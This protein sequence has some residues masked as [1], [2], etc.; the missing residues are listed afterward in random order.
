MFLAVLAI[1]SPASA[2]P[3]E[4][5]G[6]TPH[7]CTAGQT[8]N[9]TFLSRCA[10]V[11]FAPHIV[12]VGELIDGSAGPATDQCGPG[13]AAAVSWSW[14][15]YPGATNAKG[16]QPKAASCQL[17]T[18]GPTG[19]SG[20]RFVIACI[21]GSSG[22]GGWTSC[23]Y[24]AVTGAGQRAIEGRVLTKSGKPVNGATV[25]VDGPTGGTVQTDPSGSYYAVVDPGQYRVSVRSANAHDAVAFCSGHEAGSIC[26]L[27][28]RHTDGQ[29]D[30][31]APPD[32][33]ALHFS[34]SHVAADGLGHFDGSIDVTDS[35]GQPAAGTSVDVSPPLDA[36]PPALV[37]SAGK[38]VYPHVLSDG[39]RL[40]SHFALTAGADGK[41]PMSIW[42]GTV[43]GSWL[44]QAAETD[45]SSVTDSASFPFD[46]PAGATAFPPIDQLAGELYTGVRAE[47]NVPNNVSLKFDQHQT[48]E[49]QNQEI[50]LQWLIATGRGFFPGADFGP[51]RYAGHAGVLFY[52]RGSATPTAGATGVIDLRDAAAIILAA[53]TG[54]Q[55]P[56]ANNK[57]RSLDDW[58]K[59]VNGGSQTAPPRAQT[60]GP[61][62]PWT[63]QQYAYFG[64]PYPRSALD[65]TGQARF[66]N[67]C[68]APDGVPQIVQ[69][70]SPVTLVFRA[71]DGTTF[72]LDAQGQPAGTGTG[73][74][75]RRGDQVTYVVP[76]GRYTT[77]EITGTGNGPAHIEVFGVVPSVVT[78]YAR[79]ISDY[80]IAA[81]TGATGALPV[82]FFGPAGALV[83]AG[84]T[85]TPKTGL[86]IQL[87]GV[88][89]K[90]RH[91]KRALKLRATSFGAPLAGARVTLNYKGHK[92]HATTDAGGRARFTAKLPRGKLTIGV[93]FPGAAGITKTVRVR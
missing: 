52:P 3:L 15:G 85:V 87:A 62:L 31:T 6:P 51:V 36:N 69:T 12:H 54:D 20:H 7:E 45:D 10:Q 81:R 76:G 79:K 84:R 16:C 33:M 73:V 88:P 55:I 64:L 27:D 23:D 17:K 11:S 48:N 4:T 72:G 58:A 21:N 91:G 57:V 25:T 80:A 60:L 44:M 92:L 50:L 38:V 74:M 8:Q 40:G 75:F 68:A 19:T 82:N 24:Y 34:P 89:K 35:A 47:F 77:M 41:V 83:Y 63:G 49:G 32:T 78:S 30:F 9:C 93:T 86:P 28:L 14:G 53:G 29:A 26:H 13:G 18:T 71:A 67:E 61:F 22:F 56:P 70:H 43:A 46:A 1:A 59:Y 2:R 66:Y 42:P 90:L 39:T 37:C 65:A 5:L